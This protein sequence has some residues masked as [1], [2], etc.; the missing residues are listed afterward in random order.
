MDEKDQKAEPGT[1]MLGA[2]FLPMS[3]RLPR[4]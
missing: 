4:A 1:D 2:P 3:K